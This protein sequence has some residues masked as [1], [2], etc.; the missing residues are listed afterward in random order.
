MCH[1]CVIESVR[2]EMFD[3]R[4]F[5]GLAAAA[6][7]VAALAPRPAAAAEATKLGKP[8]DL[9][10]ETHENFPTYFGEQQ[11][12]V[13]KLKDIAKD[14]FNLNEWRLVE[15][16][17]TH[18]DAPLHFSAD[19]KSIAEVPVENLVAP[20]VVID[21]R[22][23]AGGNA[24][25]QVTPDD[26][27]AWIA[28]NGPLPAGCCVAMNSGWD[29]HVASDKFRNADAEKKMHFPGFHVETVKMLLD[30]GNAAGIAV[31]TLSLDYGLSP[32][33]ITHKTWLPTGRWGLEAV[34]NLGSAPAVGATLVVGASKFRGGTGGPCRVLAFV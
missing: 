23:R 4:S 34:A 2:H 32:D 14:G 25:A 11:F 3:R 22:E 33:F 7:S 27:K 30:D 12:F 9:S 20:L 31:D 8:V 17:G 24:D 21:I 13:T 19:G 29:A 18:M 10:H 26:V 5:F 6:A 16:T 28:A 15:H 1:H